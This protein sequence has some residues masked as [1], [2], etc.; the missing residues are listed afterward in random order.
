MALRRAAPP[1]DVAWLRASADRWLL[2]RKQDKVA[3]SSNGLRG[4]GQGSSDLR[5]LAVECCGATGAVPILVAAVN[6]AIGDASWHEL[7]LIFRQLEVWYPILHRSDAERPWWEKQA[8]SNQSTA[9]VVEEV[10]VANETAMVDV[11]A[12]EDARFY[13]CQGQIRR[14]WAYDEEVKRCITCRKVSKEIPG[15]VDIQ[16]G[17]PASRWAHGFTNVASGSTHCDHCLTCEDCRDRRAADDDDR[18]YD[19]VRELGDGFT[20]TAGGCGVCGDLVCGACACPGEYDEFEQ[21]QW[22][23]LVCDRCDNYFCREECCGMENPPEHTA[24]TGRWNE[25]NYYP[26]EV[27][28]VNCCTVEEL[29]MSAAMRC[30]QYEDVTYPIQPTR[31]VNLYDDPVVKEE[32]P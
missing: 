19:D 1:F 18:D 11:S 21:L 24:H 22:L 5:P 27:F 2:P 30:G 13:T 16:W 9:G 26:E 14:S 20:G 31:V 10:N 32:N 12:L 3:S 7:A 8:A 29:A 4:L 28:C 25:L 23:Y 6:E 17:H 15:G